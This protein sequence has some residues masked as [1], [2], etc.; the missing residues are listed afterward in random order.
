MAG[1]LTAAAARAIARD[2][3]AYADAKRALEAADERRRRTRA[4]YR[5]RLPVGEVVEA[6][7]YSIKVVAKTTGRK[8][9]LAEYLKAGHKVT[10]AMRPFVTEPT[11][12]EDWRV[13]PTTP[14]TS[15]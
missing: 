7:G 1:R 13:K 9:R 6:G 10:K 15:S 4:R 8:F 5:D 2:E 14:T 11:A 3:L 12:Y